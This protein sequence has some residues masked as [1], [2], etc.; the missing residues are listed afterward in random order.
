MKI[1]PCAF[2]HALIHKTG[3]ID[4]EKH[5]VTMNK[6]TFVKTRSSTQNLVQKEDFGITFLKST[7]VLVERQ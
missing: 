4:S 3:K 7:V 6:T 5:V 1:I 2:G